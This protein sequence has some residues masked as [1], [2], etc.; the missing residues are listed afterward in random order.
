MLCSNQC[1]ISIS[2]SLLDDTRYSPYANKQQL[3]LI[4]RYLKNLTVTAL[5][6]LSSYNHSAMVSGDL[7]IAPHVYS[8]LSNS[9]QFQRLNQ[10]YDIVSNDDV[11]IFGFDGLLHNGLTKQWYLGPLHENHHCTIAKYA[12]QLKSSALPSLHGLFE[13]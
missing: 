13:P 9:T 3:L 8:V 10:R 2:P 11:T 1:T 4:P 5:F 12:L 6:Y 7:E